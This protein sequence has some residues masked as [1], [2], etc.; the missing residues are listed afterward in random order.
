MSLS[1]KLK[2]DK[3]K[4]KEKPDKKKK[5][6]KNDSTTIFAKEIEDSIGWGF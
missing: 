2:E 1:E 3:A 4:Q 5:S 6:D